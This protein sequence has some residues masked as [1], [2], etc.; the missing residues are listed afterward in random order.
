M[1][2]PLE[3]D[4]DSLA[5]PDSSYF[6]TQVGSRQLA[7]PATEIAEVILVDRSQVLS[8]PFYQPGLLGVVHVQGQLVPLVT[9]QFLLE[10]ASGVTRE[11]FNA[12]QLNTS[13]QLAGIAL[14]IDQLVGN[15]TAVQLAQD[16]TIE[17]FNPEIVPAELWQPRRWMPLVV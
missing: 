13:S 10:G 11:V 12:V 9:L 2:D 5:L 15:C 8:L 17:Q 14:V 6:L 3:A 16:S 4:L 1:T 7:F